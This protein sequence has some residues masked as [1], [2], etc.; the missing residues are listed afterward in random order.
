MKADKKKLE[1]FIKQQAKKALSEFTPSA[2]SDSLL[3]ALQS[4]VKGEKEEIIFNNFK[5]WLKHN[6]PNVKIEYVDMAL[7]KNVAGFTTQ[8]AVYINK[9]NIESRGSHQQINVSFLVDTIFSTI[10]EIGHFKEFETQSEELLNTLT[11]EDYNSFIKGVIAVERRV[12]AYA[13]AEMNKINAASGLPIGYGTNKQPFDLTQYMSQYNRFMKQLHGLFLQHKDKHKTFSEFQK[14][15]AFGDLKIF[16]EGTAPAPAKPAPVIKPG[17]APTPKQRPLKIPR[18]GTFPN[19]APKAIVKNFVHGLN[20]MKEWLT[21]CKLEEEKKRMKRLISEA[22]DIP[23]GEHQPHD[24]IKHGLEARSETPF[25]VV[26]LFSKQILNQSILEKIGGEE[27]RSIV[28]N[29]EETGKMSPIEIMNTM[30]MIMTI[31]K[32]HR[33]ALQQLA[34]E[35]I[36]SKFGLPDEVSQMIDAKLVNH[37]TPTKEN[38][39]NGNRGNQNGQRR[40]Q[41]GVNRE[42]NVNANNPEQAAEEIFTPEE[43]TVIKKHAD[44]RLINNTLMMGAGY[45]AHRIFGDLEQSLNAIDRRLAPLYS[46]VMG[47]IELYMWKT[48][49]EEGFNNRQMAGKSEIKVVDTP[50]NNEPE[51]RPNNQNPRENPENEPNENQ[52]EKQIRAEATAIIFPVLLH[53]VAKAAV[54]ILFLQHLAD[55]QAKYGERVAKKVVETS[56]SYYNEHWLKLIGPVLWKHLHD[57]LIFVVTERGN[58]QTIVSFVLNKMASMEPEAFMS[59]MEDVIK[60][61]P[62]AIEKIRAIVDQVET[63]IADFENQNNE[64]P[65]PADIAG[66]NHDAEIADLLGNIEIEPE[67][68]QAAVPIKALNTMNKEE[69]SS[70]LVKA[71]GDEQYERAA[72]I[73]DFLKRV[74]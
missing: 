22:L 74:K 46:R 5:E 70:E 15:I 68:A 53:E 61:G 14:A 29:L 33:Q 71:L 19:P 72:Q 35:T 51:N 40:N 69:L 63:D 64:V 67:P 41:R 47:N 42:R 9:S 43:L 66:A 24:S 2:S 10:H 13:E 59:L 45:R 6:A 32:P 27:F 20:E 56:D 31:E 50:R 39:P 30:Q 44:K 38:S 7:P 58:D 49:V 12:D 18:P 3:V 25:S 1:E 73:R 11:N 28:Q 34:Q 60:D 55:V 8:D 17:T 16:G 37:I 52:P 26:S 57:A 65:Q 48:S 23:P 4:L 21:S 36:K 62:K 54:E